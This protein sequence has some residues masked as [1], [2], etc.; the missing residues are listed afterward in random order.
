MAWPL[1]AAAASFIGK[2]VVGKQSLATVGGALKD[3]A[4]HTIGLAGRDAVR[5]GRHGAHTMRMTREQL[6]AMQPEIRRVARL[7]QE[8]ASDFQDLDRLFKSGQAVRLSVQVERK[9]SLS[10]AA[11]ALRTEIAKLNK[12]T[13]ERIAFYGRQNAPVRTGQLR[14]SIEAQRYT[15]LRDAYV[16][17]ASVPYARHIEYGTPKMVPR[18]YLRPAVDRVRAEVRREAV[19]AVRRAVRKGAAAR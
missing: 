16:V 12:E 5:V 17:M 2:Q 18:P 7:S 13:A 14:A 3:Q 9:G 6:Q 19:E 15:R 4:A 8:L 10:V 11:Q 1:I